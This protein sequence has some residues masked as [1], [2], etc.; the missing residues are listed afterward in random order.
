LFAHE[1]DVDAPR[2]T[3]PPSASASEPSTQGPS[4]PPS[5]VVTPT[6][7]LETPSCSPS[8]TWHARTSPSWHG[9]P[10]TPSCADEAPPV[11]AAEARVAA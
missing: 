6:K 9:A 8:V 4:A 7:Q 10:C 1:S 11:R 5:H 2:A 3:M